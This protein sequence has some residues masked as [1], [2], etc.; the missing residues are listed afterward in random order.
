MNFGLTNILN[1]LF[2]YFSY[3]IVIIILNLF[4]ILFIYS[5]IIDKLF[6][7]HNKLKV[8]LCTLGKNENKYAIEFVEHYKKYGVDKIFIY[9]NNDLDGEIFDN[10]L[11][12]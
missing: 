5:L 4:I 7:N 11:Y 8:C 1:I 6:I 10:I 2:N 12:N 3:K 9:D